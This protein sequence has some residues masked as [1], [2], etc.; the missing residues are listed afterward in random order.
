MR[1][2]VHFLV[3]ALASAAL[4]A[5]FGGLATAQAPEDD[6][7]V[8]LFT[9][10]GRIW[11]GDHVSRPTADITFGGHIEKI[12]AGN[13]PADYHCR[14]TIQFHDVMG[15]EFD[16]AVF[17][18]TACRDVRSFA[19]AGDPLAGIR[20]V[21]D[22]TLNG[23]PGYTAVLRV[24][25]FSNSGGRDQIRIFLYDYPFVP[26]GPQDTIYDTNSEFSAGPDTEARTELDAGN[27]Q[28]KL[29]TRIR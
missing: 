1:P 8:T 29:E 17:Q 22:G 19:V 15:T 14:W 7:Q 9:G 6:Q 25:V 16:K 23:M 21:L 28:S 20:L 27:F 5:A 10:G 3:V 12:G 13:T 26:G 4:L 24:A 11:E 18:A 2:T